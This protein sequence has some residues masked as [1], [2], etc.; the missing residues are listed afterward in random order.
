MDQ[1]TNQVVDFSQLKNIEVKEVTILGILD[2][3]LSVVATMDRAAAW[4]CVI[5]LAH[6][7]L[8]LMYRPA[9]GYYIVRLYNFHRV[10]AGA[11]KDGA[12]KVIDYDAPIFYQ[13]AD[14]TTSLTG[15]IVPRLFV[16]TSGQVWA[17]HV[18]DKDKLPRVGYPDGLP[19]EF[20]RASVTKDPT[21]I[22]GAT[23]RG[24][25]DQARQQ[26]LTALGVLL[27]DEMT[28]DLDWVKIED[29]VD[30][31]DMGGL[32]ALYASMDKDALKRYAHELWHK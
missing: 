6:P 21:I 7:E 24:H 28:P 4:Q 8:S 1:K 17:G 11:G 15:G 22:D 27:V 32:S 16:D 20:S 9:G 10:V 23:Q 12:D 30:S 29:T 3:E 14:A 26:D 18:K 19:L 31:R 5:P 13:V 2:A 25:S